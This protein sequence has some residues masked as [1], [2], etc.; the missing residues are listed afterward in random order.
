MSAHQ[1]LGYRLTKEGH[2]LLLQV[3]GQISVMSQLAGK[4]GALKPT[5]TPDFNIQELHMALWGMERSLGRVLASTQET[6][7]V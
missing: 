3:K 4:I 2:D 7:P 1:E 6:F 5:D